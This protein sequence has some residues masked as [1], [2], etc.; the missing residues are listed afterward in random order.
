MRAIHRPD[1]VRTLS[2][3]HKESPKAKTER[4]NIGI[5]LIVTQESKPNFEN[6]S[7]PIVKIIPK[8]RDQNWLISRSDIKLP[9]KKN[10]QKA[11]KWA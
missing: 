5:R 10:E 8:S 4:K 7:T 11:P 3:N 6:P 1:S 2:E 9:L